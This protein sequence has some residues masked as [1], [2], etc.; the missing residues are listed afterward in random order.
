MVQFVRSETFFIIPMQTL[1]TVPKYSSRKFLYPGIT[2]HFE[3]RRAAF[4][5]LIKVETKNN[6]YR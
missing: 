2:I 6:R 1:F 5:E 3:E 4:E